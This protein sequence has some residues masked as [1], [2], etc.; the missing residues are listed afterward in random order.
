[1]RFLSRLVVG[2]LWVG[3]CAGVCTG[4]AANETKTIVQ[5]KVVQEPGGQGIRKVKVTLIARVSQTHPAYEVI[6]DQAGQFKVEN[7]EPGE[8]AVRLERSGYA[9]DAKTKR[10]KTIKAIAGQDTKDLVF[11][12]SRLR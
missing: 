8:D 4:Q 10:D 3:L 1:M 6:T 7:V 2:V 9:A 5:G 11:R 12:C